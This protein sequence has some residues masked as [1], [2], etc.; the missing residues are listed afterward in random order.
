MEE[1]HF[2][3]DISH[4]AIQQTSRPS[5]LLHEP[6]QRCVAPRHLASLGDPRDVLD[7]ELELALLRLEEGAAH[8][9][10]ARDGAR[11]ER[12]LVLGRA[13]AVVGH[14]GAEGEVEGAGDGEG[15]VDE[16]GG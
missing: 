16:R 8:E 3:I 5:R 15:G 9:A 2:F 11:V 4:M 14:E 7:D 12:G 6:L 10:E 13:P 1:L